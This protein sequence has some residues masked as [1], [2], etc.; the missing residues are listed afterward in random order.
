[1]PLDPYLIVY[2]TPICTPV[3]PGVNVLLAS[4]V[5]APANPR[6]IGF[7]IFNNSSNSVYVTLGPTSASSFCTQLIA[8]FATWACNDPICY[9]GVISAI[10]NAGSGVCTVHELISP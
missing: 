2:R 5:I 9:T 7:Y 3:T 8:T 6:R 1:M 10:R 4:V